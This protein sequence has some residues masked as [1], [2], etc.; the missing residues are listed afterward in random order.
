MDFDVAV[1]E[2]DLAYADEAAERVGGALAER[3]GED[4]SRDRGV[5][6]RDGGRREEGEAHHG[7]AGGSER[8][9]DW[10]RLDWWKERWGSE[11]S[12]GRVGLPRREGG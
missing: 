8:G 4:R 1:G 7:G 6:G 11:C 12:K 5:D 10:T 9:I 3:V 2:G